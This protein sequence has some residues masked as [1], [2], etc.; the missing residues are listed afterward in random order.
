MVN[1]TGENLMC[2]AQAHHPA[3]VGAAAGTDPV[4]PQPI[5]RQWA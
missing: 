4:V 2:L 1:R 3:P 5:Q